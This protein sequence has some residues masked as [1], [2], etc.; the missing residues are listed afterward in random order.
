MWMIGREK[1]MTQSYD[2]HPQ[3]T[4]SASQNYIKTLK[5]RSYTS[6][7]SALTKLENYENISQVLIDN[8][9]WTLARTLSYILTLL[10][11]CSVLPS[12]LTFLVLTMTSWWLVSM[13]MSC[14]LYFSVHKWKRYICSAW[15]CGRSRNPRR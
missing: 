1:G 9:S 3:T 6:N 11:V 4:D 12:G 14:I 10:K 8:A 5:K 13:S 7:D 2:K 15:C